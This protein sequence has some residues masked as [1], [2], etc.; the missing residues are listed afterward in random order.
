MISWGQIYKDWRQITKTGEQ[1][2]EIIAVAGKYYEVNKTS[3]RRV[4]GAWQGANLDEMINKGLTDVVLALK[5][6]SYEGSCAE[7]E[8]KNIPGKG[9]HRA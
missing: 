7:I 8:G 5:C 2:N 3:N 9:N 1:Q 4:I 6:E